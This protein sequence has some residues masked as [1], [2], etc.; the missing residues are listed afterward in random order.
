M[1]RYSWSKRITGNLQENLGK[2]NSTKFKDVI[3]TYWSEVGKFHRIKG[4]N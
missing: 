3:D 1:P 4:T 2:S